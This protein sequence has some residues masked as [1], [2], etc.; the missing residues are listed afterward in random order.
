MK[1]TVT[2]KTDK[3]V[4]ISKLAPLMPTQTLG[5]N[6]SVRV[7]IRDIK[8]VIKRAASMGITVTLVDTDSLVITPA[9]KATKIADTI[10][11]V[12]KVETKKETEKIE[13]PV[14]EEVPTPSNLDEKVEEPKVEETKKVTKTKKTTSKKTTSKKETETEEKPKKKTTAKK[15]AGKKTTALKK[16]LGNNK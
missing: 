8:G 4:N 6:Q 16:L 3:P 5:V 15:S 7:I 12:E 11:N 14:I 10:S 2:N 13:E 9:V 1:V